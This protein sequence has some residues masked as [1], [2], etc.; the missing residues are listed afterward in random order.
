[1][2]LGRVLQHA[3]VTNDIDEACRVMGRR[4]GVNQFWRPNPQTMSLDDGSNVVLHNAHAWVGPIWLELIQPKGGADALW[5]DW[6]PTDKGFAMKFHHMGIHVETEE[7]MRARIAQGEANGLKLALSLTVMG[8]MARYLD[9]REDLG[10]YLE[11]LYF[12]DP[13]TVKMPHMP[14]NMPGWSAPAQ[15]L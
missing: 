2:I 6:L 12:P 15:P 3:Y 8:T 1:M 13:E 14:Q 9:A 10:H 5:R 7:E 4:F 11:Y